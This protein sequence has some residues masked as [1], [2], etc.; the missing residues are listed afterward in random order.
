MSEF[1]ATDYQRIA[2]DLH[3]RPE[4]VAS[5]IG[6]LADG[7]TVPFIT[8]YRKEGTGHLDEEQIRS[9]QQQSQTLLQLRERA[10]NILRLIESR[11]QLTDRLRRQVLDADS[12]K[13][14]E[15]LY[16]PYR[17]K[18]R[19]RACI[20]RE[21]GLG[22]LAEMIWNG[23][24]A[25][26]TLD[27]TLE[28]FVNPQRALPDRQAVLQGVQDLLA[29]RVSDDLAVR[30]ISR[31][32]A[33]S[34]GAMCVTQLVA[35]HQEAHAF[36][37]YKQFRQSVSRLPAHRCLALNRGEKIGALRV[38]IKFEDARIRTAAHNQLQ[39]R[40][41]R[42]T[43]V[44]R[45]AIDDGLLRL[46]LPSLEREIR[47]ELTDRAEVHAIDV[48][49][50]NLNKLLLQ[51]PLPPKRVLAI[52]P[53]FRTGCKVAVLDQQGKCLT[54]DHVY[55]TGAAAKKSANRSRLAELLQ[56]FDCDLIAIGNGTA[57]RETEEMISLMNDECERDWP[58]VIVNESGASIYSTSPVAR[59]EFPS[60]DATQRGT[61]SIGRRLQDP[62]SELVKIDPQHLGVGMYQHDLNPK[63]LRESLDQVI[64]SCVN[65]VGVDLNTASTSLLKHVS[66]FNQRI[67][68]SVV[69]WRE[70]NGPFR[71]RSELLSVA[72]VGKSTFTQA[73]G[74]LKIHSG[75]EPLDGTWIHPESYRL[76]RRLLKRMSS[77][78]DEL[79]RSTPG[80]QFHNRLKQLDVPL[81]AEE[82]QLSRPSLTEMIN[83][84]ERPCR[85]PRE[86]VAGPV[87]RR[88]VLTLEDLEVGM[89]LTGT[90][91]NV[92]DFGAFVDV[93]LK[94]RG[95]VH[96]SQ[97]SERFVSDPHQFVAVGDVVTVW[98]L[99]V[100]HD[101]RR[102]SLS[103]ITPQQA[104]TPVP[105]DKP[106]V[107]N[108]KSAEPMSPRLKSTNR[109]SG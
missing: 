83:T 57:C 84:F 30:K 73:A 26:Q 66:G 68:R 8:R 19:S 64:E 91:L 99:K 33:W 106:A 76:A 48:F 63:Q 78:A 69:K 92:V 70:E 58:Y 17:V 35:D 2:D 32:L 67:A 43:A 51:P 16:R 54:T 24:A 37:D 23:D 27:V 60:F 6:L 15:D 25:I 7:N 3:V 93:G 75:V 31:D 55:L 49:A 79:L 38:R 22:P 109:G 21:R 81:L 101:R 72:G 103:M 46:V 44:L 95:L 82:F 45:D 62:L 52:D 13:Q 11:G 59:D 102:V 77:S 4:Q 96:I 39:I 1:S 56:E 29:E 86:D 9:V 18:R 34:T 36:R 105:G 89:E 107:D 85:D 47:R 10:E 42:F 61:V 98:V 90:V 97:L 14:L 87:F 100:E 5:V 104:S 53:G 80:D 74:F 28:Q 20:A 108:V 40:E 88:G 41:R 50:R 12:L 65:A 71:T 94:D